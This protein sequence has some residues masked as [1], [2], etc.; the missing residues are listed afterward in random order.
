VRRLFNVI[1]E[2]IKKA[3]FFAVFEPNDAPTWQKVKG[4]IE[5]YLYQLWEKGALAGSSAETSYFVNVGLGSTMNTQDILEGRM[6][7]EVG[8]AAV[9][10][11]EF[12]ILRFS[13][14]LQE[15]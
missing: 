1:E 9:R 14:K 13:H 4:M 2:S 7:V 8:I 3:T 12:V 6:I 15:S 5:G 10:P 11:A